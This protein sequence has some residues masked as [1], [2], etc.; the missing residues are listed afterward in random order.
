MGLSGTLID[1]LFCFFLLPLGSIGVGFSGEKSV[2]VFMMCCW[3]Q[4]CR[5]VSLDDT[6]KIS[7][8]NCLFIHCLVSREEE[9]T[10]PLDVEFVGCFHPHRVTVSS[11]PYNDPNGT[12]RSQVFVQM[13]QPKE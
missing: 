1:L 4:G 6:F 10:E 11:Q 12:T 5:G 13:A 8:I 3:Y 2:M 9:D 7:I